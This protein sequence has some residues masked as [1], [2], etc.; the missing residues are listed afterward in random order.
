[1]QDSVYSSLQ[2]AVFGILALTAGIISLRLPETF[3]QP[4]PETIADIEEHI[5]EVRDELSW[6]HVDSAKVKL[7]EAEISH[8]E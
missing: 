7:L 2:F 5:S 3:G 8:S 6:E 4:M 1:M